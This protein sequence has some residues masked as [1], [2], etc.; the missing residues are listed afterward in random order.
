MKIT[1]P[2][3]QVSFNLPS[4][5]L[6][7]GKKVSFSCPRCKE[8][9]KLDLRSKPTEDETIQLKGPISIEPD[10]EKKERGHG[11]KEKILRELDYLPAMPQVVLKAREVMA[12]P[13]SGVSDVVKVLETDQAITTKILRAHAK[14]P[15]HFGITFSGHF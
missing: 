6:P 1:C 9:I 12:D 8:K 14:I 11:L 5:K 3:C 15:S 2:N 10:E 4:E 13:D 7:I